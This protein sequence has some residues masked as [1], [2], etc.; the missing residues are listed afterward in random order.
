MVVHSGRV[1]LCSA[2]E[3]Q[4]QHDP[5]LSCN[6]QTSYCIFVIFCRINNIGDILGCPQD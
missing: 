6:A 2:H 1:D 3:S 4:I 5:A